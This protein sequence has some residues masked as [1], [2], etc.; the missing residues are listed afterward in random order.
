MDYC[1][2]YS[3][4]KISSAFLRLTTTKFIEQANFGWDAKA[5]CCKYNADGVACAI[6]VWARD[7]N[8]ILEEGTEADNLP[9]SFVLDIHGQCLRTV[10]ASW[11]EYLNGGADPRYTRWTGVL[12]AVQRLHDVSAREFATLGTTTKVQQVAAVALFCLTVETIAEAIDPL[13]TGDQW[14]TEEIDS[15]EVADMCQRRTGFDARREDIVYLVEAVNR[16]AR[17]I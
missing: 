16:Y 15:S 9:Q 6:G 1:Y 12:T 7:T 5:Q 10:H 11:T 8:T 17:S 4:L 2:S 13:D 14:R 3:R